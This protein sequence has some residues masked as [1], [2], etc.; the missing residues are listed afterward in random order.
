MQRQHIKALHNLEADLTAPNLSIL[1]HVSH[2]HDRGIRDM[3]ALQR[4]IELHFTK[5]RAQGRSAKAQ[6]GELEIGFS[7]TASLHVKRERRDWSQ[8]GAGA[9]K[10]EAA[11]CE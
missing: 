9:Q 11:D 2:R 5:L 1:P 4:L 8:N 7:E 3:N 6:D 10:Q